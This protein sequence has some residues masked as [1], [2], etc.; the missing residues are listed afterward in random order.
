M[1]DEQPRPHPLHGKIGWKATPIEQVIGERI[2][3]RRTDL[4]L[5]QEE[6]GKRVGIWLGREW[7]RQAV[8][9]A[10]KGKRAFTAAELIAVAAALGT[11]IGRLLYAPPGID[12]IKLGDAVNLGSIT[13]AGA[14]LI[15]VGDFALTLVPIVASGEPLD[16][17]QDALARLREHAESLQQGYGLIADD[18]AALHRIVT[19]VWTHADPEDAGS[20]AQGRTDDGSPSD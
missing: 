17:L 16:E 8:S 9:A 12:A 2:L 20:S 6:V 7:S 19:A 4:G 5:T 14:G 11:S 18:L 15:P 10:E 3:L 13:Y 1:S